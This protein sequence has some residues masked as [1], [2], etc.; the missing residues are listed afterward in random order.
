MTVD[1]SKVL[2]YRLFRFFGGHPVYDH[3]INI[4]CM[5]IIQQKMK[6]NNYYAYCVRV[7]GWALRDTEILFNTKSL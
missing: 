1:Q 3:L 5:H 2:K 7:V 6:P 4:V